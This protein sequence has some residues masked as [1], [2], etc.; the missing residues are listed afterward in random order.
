MLTVSYICILFSLRRCLSVIFIPIG[1]SLLQQRRRWW[2]EDLSHVKMWLV[3]QNDTIPAAALG[4]HI[5]RA[6]GFARRPWSPIS[7]DLRPFRRPVKNWLPCLLGLSAHVHKGGLLPWGAWLCQEEVGSCIS[8]CLLLSC[9]QNGISQPNNSAFAPPHASV[10]GGLHIHKNKCQL[11]RKPWN[12]F[13]PMHCPPKFWAV[14]LL[15]SF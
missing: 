12:Y 2:Q 7:Y 11:F 14:P 3:V 10:K 5:C 4:R 8:A 1:G 6:D 13:I 15:R 9:T